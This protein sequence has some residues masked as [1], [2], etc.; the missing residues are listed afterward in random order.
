MNDK[1]YILIA[2]ISI[3]LYWVFF[4]IWHFK[5]K[6]DEDDYYTGVKQKNGK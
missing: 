4:L 1:A 5:I 3:I 6:G 2:I